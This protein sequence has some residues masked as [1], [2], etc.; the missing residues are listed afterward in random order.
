M[1]NHGTSSFHRVNRRACTTSNRRRSGKSRQGR[2]SFFHGTLAN[3]VW[4]AWL[5]HQPV[6]C[7]RLQD[8]GWRMARPALCLSPL[9]REHSARR[10]AHNDPAWVLF[11]GPNCLVHPNGKQ[12]ATHPALHAIIQH[13]CSEPDQFP[14]NTADPDSGK[15]RTLFWTQLDPKDCCHYWPSTRQTEQNQSF[16]LWHGRLGAAH[17]PWRQ[18]GYPVRCWLGCLDGS[19][20]ATPLPGHRCS[21]RPCEQAEGHG[22]VCQCPS[23]NSMRITSRSTSAQLSVFVPSTKIRLTSFTTSPSDHRPPTPSSTRSGW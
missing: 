5:H 21:A 23:T 12:D 22:F 11:G 6:D 1:H 17:H 20:K 4:R 9:R 7:A 13:R 16:V 14:L 19:Q 3:S 18:A 8:T 15:H 10:I 2:S